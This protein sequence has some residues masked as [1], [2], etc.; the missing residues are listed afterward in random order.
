MSQFRFDP[1][2]PASLDE[3]IKK[4][5]ATE[6]PPDAW[7]EDMQ[8]HKM[9]YEMPVSVLEQARDDLA[10]AVGRLRAQ[11]P[12]DRKAGVLGYMAGSLSTF[13]M[14]VGSINSMKLGAPHLSQPLTAMAAGFHHC[15]Q[16][17]RIAYSHVSACPSPEMALKELN[18]YIDK[19]KRGSTGPSDAQ[20]AP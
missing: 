20:E 9:H 13:E 2:D 5:D 15:V 10:W 16:A 4:S 7:N 1:S 11:S 6:G 14:V 18:R 8:I 3:Q 17:Y 19:A 12:A